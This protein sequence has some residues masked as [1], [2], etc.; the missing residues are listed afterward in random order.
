MLG[1]QLQVLFG[2]AGFGVQEFLPKPAKHIQNKS[3]FGLFSG[4]AGHHL[5]TFTVQV[6][7]PHRRVV[8]LGD[9]RERASWSPLKTPQFRVPGLRA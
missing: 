6:G 9:V 7:G 1:K 5:P 4:I 2:L 8:I 3:S